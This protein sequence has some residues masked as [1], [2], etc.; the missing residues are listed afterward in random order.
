MNHF[1][2][3]ATYFYLSPEKAFIS[4]INYNLINF[5]KEIA[6]NNFP[7]IKKE[8]LELE[9]LYQENNQ[10]FLE[11]KKLIKNPNEELYY[12]IRKMFNNE[13][14]RKYNYVTIYYFINK[15]AYSGMIR[16]NSKG[17]FNVPF[18]RYKNFNTSLLTLEHHNQ[19]KKTEILNESYEKGFD[20]ATSKDFIFLDSPYDCVFSDYGNEVFTGE[21]NEEKH[22]KLASDFKNLSAP[23]MMIISETPLINDLYKNYIKDSYPKTYSV[24]IR[25][26]FKSEANHL[27]ITNYRENIE[28]NQKFQKF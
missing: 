21:F 5:Y 13:I 10:I 6:N 9:K 20:L 11:N 4:D 18:G 16:Y 1:S 22:R 8:L 17:Q 15:L 19:L 2:E 24:N 7:L 23:A 14:E 3:G 27:I 26:R 12:N 28:A 25:N